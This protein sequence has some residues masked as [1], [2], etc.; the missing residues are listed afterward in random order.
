M[1][2]RLAYSRRPDTVERG[3]KVHEQKK[4]EGRLEG[5]RD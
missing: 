2:T 3:G 4:N 1:D 5:G